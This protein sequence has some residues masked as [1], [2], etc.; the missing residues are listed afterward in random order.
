MLRNLSRNFSTINNTLL[1]T[2]VLIVG[3][4]AAGG[5]LACA[6]SQSPFFHR[7]NK[8]EDPKIILLDSSKLPRMCSYREPEDTTDIPSRI[9][10]PRVV[11]LSPNS[12]KLLKSLGI[13]DTVEHKCVTPFYD[14][15]VY[16]QI[17]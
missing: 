9:P 7:N 14:M 13:M 17:G 16:E 6:L 5:S 8:M 4:G 15:L 1:K 2:D 3:G 11:T 10:E 12:L